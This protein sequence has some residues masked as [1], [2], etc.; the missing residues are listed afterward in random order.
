MSQQVYAK[1]QRCTDCINSNDFDSIA[2][3]V[4]NE[5]KNYVAF[6]VSHGYIFNFDYFIAVVK[7]KTRTVDINSIISPKLSAMR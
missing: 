2:K 1:L 7:I 3:K 6:L 4:M 5:R